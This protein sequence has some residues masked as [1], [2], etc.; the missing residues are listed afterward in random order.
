M[1]IFLGVLL[2]IWVPLQAQNTTL[3]PLLS[4]S[5]PRVA[6]IKYHLVEAS[7]GQ[8]PH[9]LIIEPYGRGSR[10]CFYTEQDTD[11]PRIILPAVEFSRLRSFNMDQQLFVFMKKMYKLDIRNFEVDSTELAEDDY[12]TL[13]V[14]NYNREIAVIANSM[15][16]IHIYSYPDFV[17][18]NKVER[19]EAVQFDLPIIMND[20]L[21]FKNRKNELCAYDLMESK[22]LNSFNTGKQPAYFLGI[23]IGSFDDTISWYRSWVSN[24][25][26]RIYFTTFSG[27]IFCVDPVR[28][29]IIIENRRFRGNSANAGLISSFEL[30]LVS[31]DRIPDLIGASVDKNIYCIDGRTLNL[32]WQRFTGHENQIPLS[33]YDINGDK[34]PEVFGVNDAMTLTIIDGKDGEVLLTE[35]LAS[36]LYQTGISLADLDG[37][38]ILNLILNLNRHQ[39]Q[40]Y[41]LDQF[42]VPKNKLFWLSPF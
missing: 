26:T 11:Y 16:K 29:R 20:L 7:C 12:S 24:D 38:G 40:I 33:F 23:K 25:S 14:C 3:L 22:L 13:S 32:I 8:P 39:V 36:S 1:V 18:L 41:Q 15:K 19:D 35:S 30:Y 27:S 42:S 6:G 21:L 2:L 9:L 4:F 17:L 10:I 5:Q 31:G 37:N 34:I 28:G